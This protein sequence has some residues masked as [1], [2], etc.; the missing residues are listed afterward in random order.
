MDGCGAVRE[1]SR[2]IPFIYV[3]VPE[4]GPV[5]GIGSE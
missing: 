4:P 5:V 1:I 2:N 3:T